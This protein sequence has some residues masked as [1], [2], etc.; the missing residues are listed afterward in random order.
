[1][2]E[3]IIKVGKVV[4]IVLSIGGSV[5]TA[6]INGKENEAILEKLVEKRLIK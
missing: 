3:K 2:N 5:L 1:M 6:W 4:G